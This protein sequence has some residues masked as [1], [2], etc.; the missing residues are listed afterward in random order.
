MMNAQV[1]TDR[2]GPTPTDSAST[3]EDRA[4]INAQQV[5]RP[6]FAVRLGGFNR[7]TCGHPPV[8]TTTGAEWVVPPDVQVTPVSWLGAEIPVRV[9]ITRRTPVVSIGTLVTR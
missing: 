5:F 4:A 8:A 9:M 7:S 3:T 2:G 6:T 1:S